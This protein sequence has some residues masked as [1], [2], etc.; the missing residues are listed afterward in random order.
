MSRLHCRIAA[1]LTCLTVFWIDTSAQLTGPGA[2]RD[3]ERIEE[4]KRGSVLQQDTIT[5]LDTIVVFDPQTFV[6]TWTVVTSKYSVYDYCNQILGISNPNDLLDGR[7]M[8]ITNPDTYAPMVVRWNASVG[9][10]DT[11]QK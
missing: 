1:V 9:K 4:L 3:A 11:I 2:K 6:E 8:K 10:I 5:M 7:E